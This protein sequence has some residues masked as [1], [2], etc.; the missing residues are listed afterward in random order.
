[1]VIASI[2]MKDGHVVQLK[3]GRDLV[4]QRDDAENLISEFN[5]YGEVAIIDLDQAFGNADEKGE[6]KNTQLF[7]H[8]LRKG[9]VRVGGGINTVKKAR[10]LISLGAEKVIIGSA[11]WNSSIKDG[12]SVLNENILQELNDAIGKERVIISVDAIHG[13]IA[14][15][16]WTQTVDVSLV[17]GAKQAEKFCSELL[18]TCVEKEGCMEGT[19]M[20]LVEE[21]RKAVKCRVVVAGGVNSIEQI[22]QLEKL[23]CDVQL[24]MALYTGVVNLKDAFI[25]CL[26]YEKTGGLIPVIAQSPSGEVL[27]M[28]YANKEAFAK[29]FETRRLTFFSRTKNR[30]W[31]KGEE[32]QHYLDLIKMRADC[33]RDTV[34]ATVF[35]NGG[36]CHTGSYTC[37]CSEVDAKSNLERLYAT[38][39]ER[40]ANPR[41]G[42]YTATLDAKRVR[43]KIKEE[44]EELTD[45][46]ESKNDIIWEVTDLIY[47]MSV[48]MYKEGVTWQDIYNELDKRHKE[49]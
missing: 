34:L 1:M 18:F 49:K 33:D 9:N 25:N 38:V 29:S 43:E 12:E 40:F 16:G 21:L 30:L 24:G 28:G 13:K 20:Q 5:R 44:A 32:S 48:L 11:A 37:F 2:D 19:D 3:N 22:V 31:T 41:P 17:E 47:F 26:N 36:V 45:E 15:K 4:L 39:A 42:S 35:P 46:A 6:T 27:M 23:G 10:E 14:V 7:Q 8:L